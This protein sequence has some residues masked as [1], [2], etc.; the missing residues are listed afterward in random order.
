[1]KFDYTVKRTAMV[2]NL[3]CEHC[4]KE[5]QYDTAQIFAPTRMMGFF[6][7][8]CKHCGTTNF[9]HVDQVEYEC[10]KIDSDEIEDI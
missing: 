6:A 9:D 5:Y 7:T 8:T 3:K 2:V 1:M 10:I 4:G